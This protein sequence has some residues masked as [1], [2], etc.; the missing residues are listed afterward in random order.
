MTNPKFK[1]TPAHERLEAEIHRRRVLRARQGKPPLDDVTATTAPGLAGS[2]IRVIAGVTATPDAKETMAAVV[3]DAIADLEATKA[4]VRQDRRQRIFEKAIP[5][6]FREPFDMEKVKP[7]VDKKEIRSVL[8]WK[9]G[10][11]GL[12]VMGHTGHSKSRAMF[13]LMARLILETDMQ[14]KIID[15]IG[16]ANQAAAAFSAPQETE[17]WLAGMTNPDILAIDDFGKRA[18]KTTWEGAFAILDRRVGAGKPT[19]LTLNYDGDDIKTMIQT[20]SKSD[21]SNDAGL[22][23]PFMRRIREFFQEV[24]F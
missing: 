5:I 6:I 20:S 2:V 16:F 10:A 8:E 14:V 7:D 3:G 23:E 13:A 18:T 1:A 4:R 9:P 19:F 21:Q 11:K 17:K 15:G 24:V 22:G 12:Y